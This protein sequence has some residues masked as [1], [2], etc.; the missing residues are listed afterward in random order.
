M[1]HLATADYLVFLVYFVIVVGYGYWVYQRRRKAETNTTDF[2]LAEGSLTW[3][4]IGASLIASNISAEHFI[5]MAGSGF[6]MGLAI[7]SYEW[8]A[9][10]T[11]VIVAAF[12]IPIYLR[13]HIYTM[14]QF[15]A[16]RYSDTV[17]TIL[18]VF[19]LVVYVVVN[20]TSILYLG[21]MAIESLA[22]I[23]FTTCTVGLA[24]FAIFITLGGMKVIGYTDVIQVIV[25]VIGGL[26][27]TYLALELVADR[28]GTAGVM[29]GLSQLRSRADSHFHMYFEKGHPHYLELPGMSLVLGGMWINNLYYW[30]CNQYIVQRALG[31]DLKTARSGI[32][33]AAFLKLMIPIIAVI[34][35]IAAFV[36]FNEGS[37][38]AA[39]TDASGVVKPD[40]AYPVLMNLLPIG[41]KGLAF[42]ALTAAVVAS[43][44]GKANSISTIFTLDLYRKYVDPQASEQK[45]V[46]VGRWAVVLSFVV[47]I[48]LA[49]LLRSLDQVYQYIQE[50]TNFI[51]P[52]IFAIFLLGFFWKRATNRAAM[53]VAILTLPL[54]ILLKFWPEVTG[55]LGTTADPIPFLHRTMW[56]FCID[57]LLMVV[58]TL[59]DPASHRAQGEVVVDRALFRV[60]PSFMIGSAGIFGALA[61]LYTLFW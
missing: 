11:L 50:Y 3:W 18:A 33:F 38:R 44:A 36:L 47:A 14:P 17:S 49:P 37:F 51:T 57:I 52:G 46:R 45:L 34:P 55:W 25:L 7:S 35:G 59:T 19:W 8:I 39:M 5:G 58:V 23:S 20:L 22:G 53:T 28:S 43:L 9:A 26:V 29:N 27:V 40:H 4:A 24:L 61:V 21:A 48:G 13:N 6:A 60:T 54:S 30:G 15:L 31:A 16:Q 12:F 1:N 2:F 41:M 32:L 42:A 56:V 10:A